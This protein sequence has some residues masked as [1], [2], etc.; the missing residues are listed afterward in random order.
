MKFFGKA[1]GFSQAARN[2]KIIKDEL[3]SKENILREAH[4]L[5]T[6]IVEQF[7]EQEPKTQA[8][9]DWP[10]WK[11]LTKVE[12]QIEGVG[13]T[14]MMV[15]TGDL[16]NGVTVVE[17]A[18]G[19]WV[20]VARKAKRTKSRGVRHRSEKRSTKGKR[21]ERKPESEE[22]RKERVERRKAAEK[23]AKAAGGGGTKTKA[24]NLADIAATM[25]FGAGPIAVAITPAMRRFLFGVLFKK[26]GTRG[27]VGGKRK[28]FV[29]YSI[30]PRPFM[31]PAAEVWDET[32][33]DYLQKHLVAT[34]RKTG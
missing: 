4:R 6:L 9:G 7:N 2:L 3:T 29:V 5:R 26:A 1:F 24:G 21:K 13:G 22:K 27:T 20:G 18:R 32:L 14:S 15:R 28:G 31:R 12:R 11:P 30:P 10:A 25:E 34:L 17:T 23:I 8:Y 16:R 19:A 33:N